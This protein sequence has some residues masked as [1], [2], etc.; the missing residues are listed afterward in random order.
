MN[1]DPDAYLDSL[2]GVADSAGWS[3]RA[4]V[5]WDG[6][7]SGRT[8]T[9]DVETMRVEQPYKIVYRGM[10]AVAIK[11]ANGHLALYRLP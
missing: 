4:N 7:Q 2:A 9:F 11:H 3:S 1:G 6:D 5:K 8:L 10:P